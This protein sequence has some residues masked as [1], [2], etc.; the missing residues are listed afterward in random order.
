MAAEAA[1][2][3]LVSVARRGACAPA[4][5]GLIPISWLRRTATLL[6]RYK[7]GGKGSRAAQQSQVGERGPAGCRQLPC[8]SLARP[9]RLAAA[10]GHAPA[11]TRQQ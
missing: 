6:Q 11:E 1:E 10:H 5:V 2:V 9:Y 4:V 7:Q 3:E 8:C